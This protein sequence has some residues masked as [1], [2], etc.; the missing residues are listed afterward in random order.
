MQAEINRPTLAE[1]WRVL[2][3]ILECLEA[4]DA[5]GVARTLAV[6]GL[7]G[8]PAQAHGVCVERK[9]EVVLVFA[10]VPAEVAGVPGMARCDRVCREGPAPT[11]C[12]G[13]KLTRGDLADGPPTADP[14]KQASRSDPAGLVRFRVH[15]R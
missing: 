4:E 2:L 12:P 11:A 5:P 9:G 14:I 8:R 1:L 15:R 6:A 10:A 3:M 13:G 7:T